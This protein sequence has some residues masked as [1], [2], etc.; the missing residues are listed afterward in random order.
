MSAWISVPFTINFTSPFLT[1]RSN[2]L[3]L[4]LIIVKGSAP[5][6]AQNV[7]L[8][9]DVCVNFSKKNFQHHAGQK[10][11]KCKSESNA[12]V[13]VC[14]H[15]PR[16][17]STSQIRRNKTL[18]LLP[19]DWRT[20]LE[21]LGIIIS[22]MKRCRTKWRTNLTADNTITKK[23]SPKRRTKRNVGCEKVPTGS[24]LGVQKHHECKA[25]SFLTCGYKSSNKKASKGRITVE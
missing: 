3:K 6:K 15:P 24:T 4:I 11:K 25:I 16:L 20:R 9:A 1:W 12:P 21:W 23:T 14:R 22:G 19:H 13:N 7:Q 2:D 5:F 10:A 8:F 18:K 17:S